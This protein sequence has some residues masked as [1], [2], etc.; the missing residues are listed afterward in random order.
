M[1]RDIMAEALK[2]KKEKYEKQEN[3]ESEND[4]HEN[5]TR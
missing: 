3:T 1:T 5:S 4:M 2:L